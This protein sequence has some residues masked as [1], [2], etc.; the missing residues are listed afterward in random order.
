MSTS[1]PLPARGILTAL[2]V[3]TS[4]GCTINLPPIDGPTEGTDVGPDEVDYVDGDIADDVYEPVATPGVPLS[5]CVPSVDWINYHAADYGIGN[6]SL[7]ITPNDG[8]ILRT[9]DA[10]TSQGLVF[11]ADSGQLLAESWEHGFRI[12]DDAF[13]KRLVVQWDRVEVREMITGELIASNTFDDEAAELETGTLSPDGSRVATVSCGS[14][15]GR[16][17]HI[18]DA[19]SGVEQQTF[20]L[21]SAVPWCAGPYDPRSE[22]Q[23]THAGN[24]VLISL[25]QTGEL[26]HINLDTE[27]E[28]RIFAHA[29]V[30]VPEGE[31][32]PDD[33]ALLDFTV[34]PDDDRVVTTGGDGRL[35]LFK[36]PGLVDAGID[37]EVG[38]QI[39][40]V[41]AYLPQRR[42]SPVAF[43]RDGQLLAFMGADGKAYLANA[44]NLDD[45]VCLE[46]SFEGQDDGI[47]W[48][49]GEGERPFSF[50]F[51]R[52]NEA[53]VAYFGRGLVSFSCGGAGPNLNHG[54]PLAVDLDV[55]STTVR[56]S[57]TVFT[58][59]H[60][61]DPHVHAHSFYVD[62]E[63]IQ[64][65][66]L[67]RSATW[68]PVEAG[69]FEVTVVVDDGVSSGS[70]SRTLTVVP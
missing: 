13:R 53:V 32:V 33:R 22:V 2:L 44:R 29:P 16:R 60:I 28:S 15:A 62:G 14:E 3:A 47:F 67:G 57:A 45:R 58:A 26:I 9:T 25:D 65:G 64:G 8:L 59:T 11:R 66:G 55:P 10:Y 27:E 48:P 43:S 46:V 38:W 40:N 35:H 50:A 4:V 39:I 68:Y 18:I 34:S 52:D 5:E 23:F 41:S 17:L 24:A 30:E 61:G 56:G 54:H 63:L 1:R 37:L 19:E 42:V 6:T 21:E 36:L 69:T 70:A 31:W 7:S 51:A 20:F 12:A 49:E